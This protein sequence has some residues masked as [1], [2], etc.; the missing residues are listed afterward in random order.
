MFT[1]HV[2]CSCGA[3]TVSFK[4]MYTMFCIRS[5]VSMEE[6]LESCKNLLQEMIS[7]VE[8]LK[9]QVCITSD[10][11]YKPVCMYVL[12]YMYVNYTFGQQHGPV[13]VETY[14]HTKHVAY[15]VLL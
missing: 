1:V 2:T 12:T 7:G 13:H 14:L 5:Y 3:F 10:C 6:H 4:V 15:Y 8:M 9:K 11:H